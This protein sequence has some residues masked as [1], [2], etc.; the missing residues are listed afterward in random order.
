MC[1]LDP[2]HLWAAL[3][4]AELNPVRAGLAAEPEALAWFPPLMHRAMLMTLYSTGTRRAGG[5]QGAKMENPVTMKALI[6]V[7]GD[8]LAARTY[9][10]SPRGMGTSIAR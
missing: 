10:A 9:F 6:S 2:P 5:N 8:P 7:L 4:Y 1:P 3:R